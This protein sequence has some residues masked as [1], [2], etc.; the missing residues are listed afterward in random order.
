MPRE[1]TLATFNYFIK[2]AISAGS[3]YIQLV[4]FMHDVGDGV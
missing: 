3:A 2:E 1:E 4:R